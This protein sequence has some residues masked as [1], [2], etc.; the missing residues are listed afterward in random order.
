MNI[1]KAI[2]SV[3]S[4]ILSKLGLFMKPIIKQGEDIYDTLTDDEKKAAQWASGIIAVVN[5]NIDAAPP[6]I[7]DLLKIKFPDLSLD[8]VHGFLET[9]LTKISNVQTEIPV[10]LEDAITGLQKYLKQ[11]EGDNNIWGIISKTATTILTVLFSPETPAQKIE[12][13]LEYVYHLIVKPHVNTT[14]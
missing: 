10:T 14:S 1:L 4:G 7:I 8:V 3:L 2:W 12:A 11:H 13:V 9:L 6:V 5:Q